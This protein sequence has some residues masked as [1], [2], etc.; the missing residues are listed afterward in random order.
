MLAAA[1]SA[2]PPR[3]PAAAG[4]AAASAPLPAPAAAADVELPPEL[5]GV[6]LASQAMLLRDIELEGLRKRCGAQAA[7]SQ[8]GAAGKKR[9]QDGGGGGGKSSDKADSKQLS[10]ASMFG[11]KANK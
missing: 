11:K 4:V 9:K 5:A 6:D 2:G 10:I 8:G 7:G 1:H 3:L